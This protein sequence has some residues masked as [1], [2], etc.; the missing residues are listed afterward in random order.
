[1]DLGCHGFLNFVKESI[2][3]RVGN[4]FAFTRNNVFTKENDD[5]ESLLNFPFVHEGKD[6]L[7][8]HIW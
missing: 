6:S 3:R 2:V 7:T 4:Y 5:K 8:K 1:M